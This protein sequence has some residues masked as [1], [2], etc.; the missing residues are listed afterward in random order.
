MHQQ[1]T[2]F[3]NIYIQFSLSLKK[4]KKKKK[5]KKRDQYK[6]TYYTLLRIQ[7]NMQYAVRRKST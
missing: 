2:Q 4:K 3:P 7:H 5:K 1:V 6:Y